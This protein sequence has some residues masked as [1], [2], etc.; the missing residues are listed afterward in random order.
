MSLTPAQRR[1]ALKKLPGWQKVRGRD[2]ITK[3]YV[4]SDFVQAFGWMT[5][6]AL[7]AE[8]MNHHP[9]WKNVYRTVDVVLSTHDAG[10][11]TVLDIELATAMEKFL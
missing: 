1:A 10:G 5:Q 7:V 8:R 11:V 6:V 2:A 9:E 4:F 3:T